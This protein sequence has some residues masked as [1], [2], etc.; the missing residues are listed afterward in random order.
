[1]EKQAGNTGPGWASAEADS[2]LLPKHESQTA[3]SCI[4]ESLTWNGFAPHTRPSILASISCKPIS[5]NNMLFS[6]QRFCA[7]SRWKK[8]QKQMTKWKPSSYRY[9]AGFQLPTAEN[10]F[11]LSLHPSQIRRIEYTANPHR[12]RAQSSDKDGRLE[13]ASRA[14]LSAGSSPQVAQH[15]IIRMG[16]DQLPPT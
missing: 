9:A 15:Q 13:V 6:H 3:G 12:R 2:H 1:M 5:G 10:P 16:C 8:N 4:T 7:A 14:N 11:S